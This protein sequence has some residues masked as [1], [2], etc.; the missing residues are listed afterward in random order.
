SWFIRRLRAHLDN[1]AGHSLHS[2]GATWLASLG[3]PVELIQAIGWWASESFKIYIRTHP[4]LL[5]T[6]LFSQQPATA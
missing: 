4:V 6:L 5:T 1:V 3:V 2:G